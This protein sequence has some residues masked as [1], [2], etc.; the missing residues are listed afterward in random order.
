MTCNQNSQ[1][2][3]KPP[4]SENTNFQADRDG[5]KEL[6]RENQ[7]EES[8][9]PRS[10][11][12]QVKIC[13]TAV[14]PSVNSQ[15][16]LHSK[17]LLLEWIETGDDSEV[18]LLNGLGSN[19]L[20]GPRR[21]SFQGVIIKEGIALRFPCAFEIPSFENT[22]IR[23]FSVV[24]LSTQSRGATEEK[25]KALWI[26]LAYV[27]RKNHPFNMNPF[28]GIEEAGTPVYTSLTKQYARRGETPNN[29]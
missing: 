3:N 19:N 26:F 7:S 15:P 13:S 11:G 21:K 22:V 5:P 17:I 29:C 16:G 2:C 12:T 4:N 28:V 10:R 25:H 14:T 27:N 1:F 6:R 9:S 18:S 20:I 24:H 8:L 23:S